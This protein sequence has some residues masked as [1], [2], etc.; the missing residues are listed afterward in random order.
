MHEL[1]IAASVLQEARQEAMRRP[2]RL[3]KVKVRVGEL[4]GVNPEA[5]S[6]S[7]EVLARD[8]RM[9][10]L[11]LEIESCVR[12]QRCRACDQTFVVAGYDLICP[13][14]GA[15]DTEFVSGDELELASLEMEDYEPS[16]AG[17]QNSQ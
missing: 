1:G 12:R 8:A 4:S 2:G 9:E 17:A 11:E 3:R 15:A 10:P 13:A 6:F 16:A 14:C 7:F 5:L